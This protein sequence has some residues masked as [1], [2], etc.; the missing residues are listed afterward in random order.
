M[1]N[2]INCKI[3]NKQFENVRNLSSHLKKHN[4]QKEEYYKKYLLK[5]EYEGMCLECGKNHI[6]LIDLTIHLALKHN[7]KRIDQ[8]QYYIQYVMDK[9]EN[10]KCIVCGKKATF[11]NLEKGYKKYCGSKCGTIHK[12]K[13]Q[14]NIIFEF[15]DKFIDIDKS[16]KFICRI[17]G[18]DLKNNHKLTSHLRENH[19]IWRKHH[20][21]YYKKYLMI[22]REDKCKYC[23][24]ET[25]F[26]T[27]SSGF[28]KYCSH[29]CYS[30]WVN[31]KTYSELYSE[32]TSKKI[33]TASSNRIVTDEE[34]LNTSKRMKLNNPMH[35]KYG[36]KYTG[37]SHSERMK[38]NNP[39]KK[40][41]NR[42]KVRNTLLE[43]HPSRGKTYEQIYGP[44]KAVEMKNERR[45][46]ILTGGAAKARRGLKRPSAPQIELFKLVK[47][48]FPD[49]ELEYPCCNKSIDIAIVDH[50][51]AIEYDEP[52]WHQD[53]VY[54]KKRKTLIESKGW[55]FIN[56]VKIPILDELKND[57]NSLI[58]RR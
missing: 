41:E 50:M 38:L 37:M 27:I 45:E 13:K 46:L 16:K 23:G 44:E 51:I 22:G 56:Y 49:A 35:K 21:E 5:N 25:E 57:I 12:F 29:K 10:N 31:G 20:E 58:Q 33:R 32:E 2:K 24:K 54:D 43:N 19:G 40:Q 18:K 11:H 52:Y 3:C 7:I 26:L 48:L 39:M 17:C 36:K 6:K 14:K 42:E 4:I 34:R 28:Q 53:K 9:N 8:E 15:H 1:N 47:K 55:K 30:K